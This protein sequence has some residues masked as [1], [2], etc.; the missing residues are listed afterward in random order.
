LQATRNPANHRVS[1]FNFLRHCLHQR[2]QCRGN[3]LCPLTWYWSHQKSRRTPATLS[4]CA[5][6]PDHDCIWSNRWDS[7]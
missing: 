1:F 3:F 7:A 4:G 5:P 6:T 2:K